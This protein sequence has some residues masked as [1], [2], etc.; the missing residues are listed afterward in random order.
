MNCGRQNGSITITGASGGT[1]PYTYSVDGS[2]YSS[3]TSYDGLSAGI[4]TI[5]VK[6]ANGC[7]YLE[8]VEIDN[9][10]GPTSVQV[11]P[12][13]SE[14]G[15]ANGSFIIDDVNGGREPY[16]YSING[17]DFTSETSYPDLAAGSYTIDV[18]DDNNCVFRTIVNI[19]SNGGPTDANVNVTNADCGVDNGRINIT[20]VTGGTEPY[21]YS[22]DG[23]DYGSTT[24]FPN[25]PAGPHS[26]DIRRIGR[27]PRLFG[28]ELR[29]KQ[30]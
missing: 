24:N 26:I 18:R 2:D 17:G 9:S 14:C 13:P 28:K 7:L 16:M 5:Q 10:G 11:T 29:L 8:T 3:N 19:S 15:A 6:D 20:G 30:Q 23:G 21:S 25:L 27:I 12:T 4:H 1:G 22:V